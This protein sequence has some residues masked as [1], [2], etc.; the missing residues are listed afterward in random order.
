MREPSE[1]EVMH[2]L[3][4]MLASLDL[5]RERELDRDRDRPWSL[6]SPIP[7]SFSGGSVQFRMTMGRTPSP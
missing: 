3:N 1:F 5:D 2:D 6:K 7:E 4:G